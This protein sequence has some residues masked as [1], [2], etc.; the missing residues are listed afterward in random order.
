MATL[1]CHASG[2][3]YTINWSL[4]KQNKTLMLSST[5]NSGMIIP[6]VSLSHEGIYY[7][8]I[9]GDH[10]DVRKH[11][12]F[13]VSVYGKVVVKRIDICHILHVFIILS[14]R[15]MQTNYSDIFSFYVVKRG[16]CQLSFFFCFG[17]V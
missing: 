2:S 9:I 12:I 10:G 1:P 13:N 8:A 17:V 5:E 16:P 14:F 3:N 6:N 4:T 11:C 15:N 7:G